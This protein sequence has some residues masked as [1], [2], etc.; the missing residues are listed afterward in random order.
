[1]RQERGRIYGWITLVAL[2]LGGL[3]AFI[4]F[5]VGD[6][7]ASLQLEF[8]SAVGLRPGA[9]VRF[10]GVLAGS[11]QSIEHTRNPQCPHGNGQ[12]AVIVTIL[13]EEMPFQTLRH[14]A[15]FW[16]TTPGPLAELHVEV[17]PGHPESPTVG[18]D[19]LL[20]GMPP[21]N[22]EEYGARAEHALKEFIT[23]RDRSEV[24]L[25]ELLETMKG[26]REHAQRTADTFR[27][28]SPIIYEHSLRFGARMTSL[29]SHSA[30][31]G[32]IASSSAALRADVEVLQEEIHSAQSRIHRKLRKLTKQTD[33]TR[34]RLASL[35][36]DI[37]P[38]IAGVR[39][40]ATR[41]DQNMAAIEEKAQDPRNSLGAL[42]KDLEMS[43]II[44]GMKR[45]LERNIWMFVVPGRNSTP[46]APAH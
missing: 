34:R 21:L 4:S 11:V 31:D 46:I 44:K 33:A 27:A 24:Q 36:P 39:A 12:T 41:L 26:A 5:G 40:M 1:M 14:D 28:H 15:Q 43:N 30:M 18:P 37:L 25:D 42:S 19:A 8:T 29:K 45:A 32:T 13:V 35:L 7:G 20:C 6:D 22:T 23:I 16:L 17:D 3:W 38:A 9:A 2:A 10:S